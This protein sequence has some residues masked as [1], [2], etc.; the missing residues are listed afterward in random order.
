M[1]TWNQHD[2]PPWVKVSTS[3]WLSLCIASS[4]TPNGCTSFS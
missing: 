2:A 1:S 3:V 4:H